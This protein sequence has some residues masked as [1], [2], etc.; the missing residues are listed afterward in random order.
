MKSKNSR[1]WYLFIQSFKEA[2]HCYWGDR[3]VILYNIDFYFLFFIYLILV[4]ILLLSIS[5]FTLIEQKLIG[6]TQR[7]NGPYYL[8][9]L[10]LA[11]PFADAVKLYSKKNNLEAILPKLIF[12]LRP[13]IRLLITFFMWC[14][15]P[16]YF[17]GLD[18]KTGLIF[19][20]VILRLSVLPILFISWFSNCK[21]S[22]LGGLR[23]VCQIVSYEVS[24]RFVVLSLGIIYKSFNF[25]LYNNF[26]FFFLSF[27]P[28]LLCWLINILAERNRTP[29]DFSEGESELVSGFNTEYSGAPFA[30]CFIREYLRI[31]FFSLI[32]F[33]FFFKGVNWLG[34][35][36]FA[37]FYVLVRCFLPRYRYDKLIRFCWKRFIPFRI[38]FFFFSSGFFI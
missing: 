21:Y 5:F 37:F 18:I 2:I 31:L 4:I 38:L 14:L 20:I 10:G 34:F 6:V 36:F 8:G 30:F 28:L 33:F 27:S 13:S 22:I 11:Q 16:F 25:S 24:L 26:F 15:N 32:T 29:F 23:R 1:F 35:F 3:L 17:G 12:N 7:R 9:F 19:L